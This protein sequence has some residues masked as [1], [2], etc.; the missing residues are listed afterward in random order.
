MVIKKRT[1]LVVITNNNK[2]KTSKQDKSCLHVQ[3]SKKIGKRYRLKSLVDQAVNWS[4]SKFFEFV[5]MM[6]AAEVLSSFN[7]TTESTTTTTTN[8][9]A[10]LRQDGTPCILKTFTFDSLQPQPKQ[11]QTPQQLPK[12]N[13]W[14]LFG[15]QTFRVTML[16]QCLH[17]EPSTYTTYAMI[18]N[19][20]DANEKKKKKNDTLS[21]DA[22]NLLVFN[23]NN[24][25]NP[26]NDNMRLDVTPQSI[27]YV[28]VAVRKHPDT[29]RI[30]NILHTTDTE[31]CWCGRC[32]RSADDDGSAHVFQDT[33]VRCAR[34]MVLADILIDK[35]RLLPAAAA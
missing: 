18:D 33:T 34:N 8:E 35:D 26:D 16:P 21:V 6:N 19:K 20:Y 29:G 9:N 30:V 32:K 3:E 1:P 25:Q 12:P 28:T 7:K 31:A 2:K 10:Q 23:N 13:D 17:T 24:K 14:C 15:E 4:I 5:D 11:Q 27:E 22:C